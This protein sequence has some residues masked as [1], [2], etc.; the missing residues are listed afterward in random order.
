MGNFAPHLTNCLLDVKLV[1]FYFDGFIHS[2]MLLSEATEDKMGAACLH[3]QRPIDYQKFGL[4]EN[5]CDFIG[6]ALAL[7]RD[8][9]YRNKPCSETIKRIKLYSDSLARYGE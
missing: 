3:G 6:H 8:D 7:Y 9:Q 5:T 2:P 1:C 4:D